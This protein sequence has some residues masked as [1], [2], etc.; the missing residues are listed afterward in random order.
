[1]TILILALLAFVAAAAVAAVQ[2][3]W[4]VALIAAGLALTVLHQLPIHV[5]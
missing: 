4:A 1:M 5:G 3:S 2:R